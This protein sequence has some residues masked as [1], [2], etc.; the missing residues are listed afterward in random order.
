M[1]NPSTRYGH[2][3]SE[4][5]LWLFPGGRPAAV[6]YPLGHPTPHAYGFLL[7]KADEGRSQGEAGDESRHIFGMA[8]WKKRKV[9]DR[10]SHFM[11]LGCN[12]V[13]IHFLTLSAPFGA[14][15]STANTQKITRTT[16]LSTKPKRLR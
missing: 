1:P 6:F 11:L 15:Q 8:I 7:S 5:T 12:G 9:F 14:S 4:T 2:A 16:F 3:N 13:K 10:A